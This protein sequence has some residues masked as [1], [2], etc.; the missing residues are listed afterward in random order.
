MLKVNR[1][2]RRIISSIFKGKV[3]KSELAACFLSGFFLGLFFDPEYGGGMFLRNVG[4]HS[5]L[6]IALNTRRQNSF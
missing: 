6:Y 4:R 1:R 2:F 5:T 3:E